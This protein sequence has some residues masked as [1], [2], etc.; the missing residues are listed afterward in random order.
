[1]V[2]TSMTSCNR[3]SNDSKEEREEVM[4]NF[5]SWRKVKVDPESIRMSPCVCGG[6]PVIHMSRW[7][8]AIWVSCESCEVTTFD[9]H[10]DYS[11]SGE[12]EQRSLWNK[13]VSALREKAYKDALRKGKMAVYCP[14][15]RC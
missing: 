9:E 7:D 5:G 8:D 14:K 2:T 13:K 10:S 1:M 11:D 15:G 3:F 12:M 4:F 6:K